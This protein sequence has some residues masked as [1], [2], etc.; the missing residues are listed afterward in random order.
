MFLGNGSGGFAAA[1]NFTAGATTG[2]GPHGVAVGDINSDGK[3]DVII[4]NATLGTVTTHLQN[5]GAF[6]FGAGITYTVGTTPRAVA[7]AD[8]NGDGHLDI[9]VA[10]SGSTNV[11]V[12]LWTG[13]NAFGTPV[14]F[15]TGTTTPWAI[16]SADFN[17]DGRPDLATANA[18]TAGTASVLFNTCNAPDLSVT[19]SH[20]GDF[21]VGVPATYTLQVNNV[22]AGISSGTT[23][24]TDTL[25]TGLSLCQAAAPDG[26]AR[27]LVRPS[28]APP[29]SPSPS[30]AARRSTWP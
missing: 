1:L 21:T 22:G 13:P 23:T 6:G 5:A 14:Q 28:R 20:T 7:M 18:I 16:I 4:A 19:S 24:V 27:R 10:N 8:V 3:P 2:A 17:G 25:P 26:A 29:P 9:A 11:S 12:L 30:A 15:S